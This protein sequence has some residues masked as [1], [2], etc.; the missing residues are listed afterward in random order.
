[1]SDGSAKK[2]SAALLAGEC[3]ELFFQQALDSILLLEVSTEGEPVILDVNPAALRIYGYSRAELVGRPVSILNESADSADA[4]M[5]KVCGVPAGGGINFEVRHKRK[6]GSV[7]TVEASGHDML[8]GGRRLAISVERDI[9]ERRKAENTLKDSEGK[10]RNLFESSRDALMT[11]APPSWRFNSGNP[12]ALALF[13]AKDGAEFAACTPWD[14]SPARQPDGRA[15]EEEARD[16]MAT[17]LR[18]GS[19]FFCVDEQAS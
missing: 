7:F 17:A 11:M 10:Y 9:T 12:A 4:L 3:R 13:R 2:D 1:M 5:K 16:M 6:D 15:S 18:E 14:L 19:H 8:V